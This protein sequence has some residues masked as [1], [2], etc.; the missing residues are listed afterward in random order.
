MAKELKDIGEEYRKASRDSF[1]SVV[2]SAGEIHKGFQGIASEMTE[3]FAPGLGDML[4]P[5]RFVSSPNLQGQPSL[6]QYPTTQP[7]PQK[8]KS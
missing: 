3:Q 2:R 4:F 5:W 8:G 7:A 6:Q 1:A